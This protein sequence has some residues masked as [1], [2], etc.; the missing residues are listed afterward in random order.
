MVIA[1]A[2]LFGLLFWVVDGLVDYY[3]YR[4]HVRFLIF[5]APENILDSLFLN[6]STPDLFARITL[7]AT[8]LIAGSLLARL[9]HRQM[10]S[11]EA[12][13]ASEIRYRRLHESMRDAFVQMDMQGRI[14]DCNTAFAQMLGRS[15]AQLRTM[16]QEDLTPEMWRALE[17]RIIQEQ[18]V[19][20]G[21]S[22]VY[23]KEL[24]RDDG[25]ILPVELRTFLI[26]D[27]GGH[28]MAMWAIVRDIS[29]RKR[30]EREREA[31]LAALKRSNEDLQRFAY[32]AS[33]DLQEPLR[34]VS[35]YTSL[36]AERYA[37]QLD[38]QAR[39]Y[40]RYAV[41]GALRMQTL[42]RDLLTLSRVETR[43][44][45]LQT[46]EAGPALNKAIANLKAMIDE[47]GA[48][49]SNDPL[50]RVQADE[51]QMT[52]VFQNLMH[53]SLKFRRATPP[54]IHVSAA[55]DREA[56]GWRFAVQDDGIG[57]DAQYADKIFVIFKRLHT[58]AEYPGTGI[59][60]ALCKRIIERHRGRIWLESVPGQGTTFYFTL[61]AAPI[62]D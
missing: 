13:R 8:C 10:E 39:K 19:P 61:P 34:M 18:V 38:D 40:I 4:E 50:P 48:K 26:T 55:A 16:H 43:G 58:Q 15:M 17:A 29:E 37:A 60:L 33:H 12:L 49:I 47:T 52:A 24:I 9:L 62:G 1:A 14:T 44:A 46:V 28:P 7:M 59:G 3:K 20:G 57:I 32:V 31:A 53:N 41:D 21:K 2:L 23:E 11:A 6:V 51:A 30:G 27:E 35:S 22:D 42:I 56:G 36:L 45:G 5:K 25:S 54:H